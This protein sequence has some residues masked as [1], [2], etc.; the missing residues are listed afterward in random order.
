MPLS[1]RNDRGTV[2]NSE[3]AEQAAQAA[4]WRRATAVVRRGARA[5]HEARLW[6]DTRQRRSLLVA[7]V[8]LIGLVGCWL[9]LLA[10]GNLTAGVGPLQTKL[11][12]QP[13]LHGGRFVAIPPLGELRVKTHAGPWR[14]A[15]EVTR[16]NA[17]DA[18]RIFNDPDSVNGLGD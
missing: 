7:E 15:I 9:G 5:V 11:S 17:A 14:L 18:R 13:S 4:W 6:Q 2:I 1:A 12:V 16:I 8:I 10:G 3:Q